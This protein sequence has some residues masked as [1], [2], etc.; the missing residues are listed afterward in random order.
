MK[1]AIRCIYYKP[2]TPSCDII[3]MDYETWM[4]FLHSDM[5]KR[6]EIALRL[7]GRNPMLSVREIAWIPLND[8]DK[9]QET[10]P[11]VIKKRSKRPSI[12]YAELLKAFK[13]GIETDA[14]KYAYYNFDGVTTTLENMEI[15]EFKELIEKLTIGE[16]D[17]RNFVDGISPR[18]ASDSWVFEAVSDDLTSKMSLQEYRKAAIEW[19]KQT[20][21]STSRL[22]AM[23]DEILASYKEDLFSP[24]ALAYG[25]DLGYI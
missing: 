2:V 24:T 12:P 3:D 15:D 20:S 13:K 9:L 8:Q 14:K 6:K 22:E 7:L 5:S 18:S 23:S 10:P 11:S 19:A 17:M 16:R 4:D 1:V 21:L 25:L